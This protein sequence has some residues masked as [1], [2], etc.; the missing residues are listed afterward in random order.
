MNSEPAADDRIFFSG[1]HGRFD[2]DLE[3]LIK[4]KN[5]NDQQD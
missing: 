5:Y 4:D 2:K 1:N 3:G